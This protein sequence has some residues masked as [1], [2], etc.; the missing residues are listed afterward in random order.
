MNKTNTT[1]KVIIRKKG[2]ENNNEKEI[3][4]EK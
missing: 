2:I 1:I 4:E 3:R